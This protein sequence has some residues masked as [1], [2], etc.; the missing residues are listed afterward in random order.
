MSNRTIYKRGPVSTRR[1]SR[2]GFTLIEALVY[3]GL[4]ALLMGGAVIASY[5]VFESS[6]RGTAR[7]LL[8]EEGNFL[9]AKISWALSGAQAVTTPNIATL[10]CSAPSNM[11]SVA[12]WDASVGVVTVAQS[13]GSATLAKSGTTLG[14]T[15]PDV[16]VSNLEFTHCWA[17]G[18]NPESIETTFTLSTRN[19]SGAQVSQDFSS[20]EYVRR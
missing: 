2:G 5:D 16:Q 1:L 6:G 10:P 15:S 18:S 4:F 20:T 14:I 11:L 19:S 9:L 17:G 12:K 7:G 13:G 3:L 8:E